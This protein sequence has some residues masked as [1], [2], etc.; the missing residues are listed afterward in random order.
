MDQVEELVWKE[1]FNVGVDYIDEAHKKLFSIIRRVLRMTREGDYATN[2]HSCLGAVKF[3]ESY[4]VSHFAAEEAYQ[5]S[6]KYPGYEMHKALHD[7]LKSVTLPH[8]KE[9]MERLDYSAEA[10]GQLMGF[11]AGWL[12]G[13]ILIE[14]RAIT[15]R[16]ESRWA[17][18]HRSD[19][20]ELLNHEFVQFMREFFGS[21]AK[22]VN[23]HYGG[24][25]IGEAIYYN[26]EYKDEAGELY[27]VIMIA[28][29]PAAKFMAGK[30]LGYK[31]TVL[32]KA[33]F[34]AYVEL[35]RSCAHQALKFIEPEGQF[36]FHQ[37]RALKDY[38]LA[39]R[40]KSGFPNI[41]IMWNIAEG[42][43]GLCVEKLGLSAAK[44]SDG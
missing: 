23:R 42:K 43:I 6:V 39:E 26:M 15:G 12:T 24:E 22:L 3:F 11:M 8:L 7:N 16:A 36:L 34:G 21:E 9:E 5:R 17:Q 37:H 32:D 4:A 40:F 31:C 35:A 27:D 44:E 19:I 10:V 29:T 30:M 14:D 38:E 18:E 33:T 2:K 13:H 41:S 1:E 28:E 20:I 25:K